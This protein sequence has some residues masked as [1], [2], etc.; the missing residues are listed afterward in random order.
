[1]GKHG[2]GLISTHDLDLIKLA[3]EM[4]SVVNYHFRDA[5]ADE[6][7]VFDYRLREGPCPTTNA[8]KIMALEGLPV[9]GN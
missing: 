6:R 7:M 1:M 3:D 2:A 8:L 9:E 5:I 4:S